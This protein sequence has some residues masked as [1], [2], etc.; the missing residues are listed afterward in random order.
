[1]T[2]NNTKVTK[3]VS[4]FGAGNAGL[5][6]AYHF[7]QQGCQVA[8]Y[9]SDGF[10]EQIHAITANGGIRSLAKYHGTALDY[11]GFEFIVGY[12]DYLTF[13]SLDGDIDVDVSFNVSS[14]KNST[15]ALIR[16]AFTF[17][18]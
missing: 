4:V 16:S 13:D 3:K 17:S 5:T 8:L 7:T 1:M 14:A 15:W 10:D 18:D 11:S 2:I 12:A 9:G 6:A